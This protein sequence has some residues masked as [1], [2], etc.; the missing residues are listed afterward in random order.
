MT[1]PAALT[2]ALLAVKGAGK[3]A[4]EV[5]EEVVKAAKAAPEDTQVT[6]AGPTKAI[7]IKLDYSRYTKLRDEVH[8]RQRSGDKTTGQ[9]ILI[10]ALDM[11]MRKHGKSGK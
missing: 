5:A 6:I 9:D 7:T 1:K 3:P 10:E 8:L 4:V 2:P 11:W